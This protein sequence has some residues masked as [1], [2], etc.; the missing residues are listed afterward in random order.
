MASNQDTPCVT[1]HHAASR[2]YKRRLGE[3]E[4]E[5]RLA[6][7]PQPRIVA[8]RA[9]DV[10]PHEH[11]ADPVPMEGIDALRSECQNSG[12]ENDSDDMYVEEATSDAP[13]GDLSFEDGLRMWALQSGLPHSSLNC[14][15]DHLRQHNL[16]M[17]QDARAFMSTPVPTAPE[18]V[19]TS[20]AGGQLWYQ[21][22]EK[23]LLS[24]FRKVQPIQEGFELDFFVD[25]LPLRKSSRSQFWPILMKINNDPNT[26]V[27]TVAMFCGESQPA[28][29]EEFL[30]PFVE[31][32]NKLNR[33]KVII[34]ARAYWVCPRSII[35]DVPARAFIS[36]VEPRN[37]ISACMKC[38]IE[39][40]MEQNQIFFR[41]DA[42]RQSRNHEDFCEDKYP[43]HVINPT[44]LTTMDR[45]DIIRDLIAAEDVQ[46]IYKGV[47]AKLM[48]LWM[49]GF[50]GVQCML[51]PQQQ[52]EV[53]AH[54]RL[55]KLPSDF[56][57]KLRDLRY[58]PLWKASEHRM[59]LLVAGFVVLK[60]RL[61]EAAYEHFMLLFLAVTFLSTS[62]HR[63]KWAMADDLLHRFVEAYGNV[64]SPVLLDSN[65]HNLLH[66]H[67]DVCR[68]DAL[69]TLSA[70]VFQAF[71]LDLKKLM[72]SGRC[73]LVQ[74]VHRVL[75]LQQVHFAPPE[76]I[77]AD[78]Q[79]VRTV[80]VDTIA[81]V[82][83]GFILRKNVRDQWC[84]TDLGEVIR[85]ESATKAE[86]T[87]IVQGYTFSKQM[88]AFT[89]PYLS[90]EANIYSANMADLDT[91]AL[92][93]F[94]SSTLMC[95]LAAVEMENE[96]EFMF[97]PLL[98]TYIVHK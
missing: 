97:V 47:E 45:C 83:R 80:G 23:S 88:I 1:V 75:E 22:I 86:G 71:L 5:L 87:V 42:E 84:M 17:P 55:L 65:V 19:L 72:R 76:S 77:P 9:N 39:G 91:A 58:V 69:H 73:N 7:Q 82:R 8:D 34:G 64:Y 81:T 66:I 79:S 27:M 29:V 15:L 60:G 56:Q 92:H 96:G 35:A 48:H 37:A 28:F 18:I 51:T 53:S 95:K 16:Q 10:V 2:A 4:R 70:S 26:P 61:N 89:E 93:S 67:N 40:E 46:L 41:Y 43:T 36:G 21:G 31:E 94:P 6:W 52:R 57:H 59:F 38:T 12:E 13:Y 30:R 14:L 50:P 49:E 74:A 90:T 78:E 24:Y 44:P 3:M 20:I 54:L 68:F 25:G 63:D 11:E 98:H 33:T 62:Y 32:M 85:Y